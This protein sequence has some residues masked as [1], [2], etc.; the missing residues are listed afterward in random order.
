MRGNVSRALLVIVLLAAAGSWRLAT[1]AQG[2]SEAERQLQKAILV[3]TV[4]GNLQ[5]AIDQYK[6]IVAEN[7]GNRVIAAR[8]LLRL[9]GCYE[10][11]GQTEAEKTYRQLITDYAD[12]A[13]EVALARQKLAALT[14]PPGSARGSAMTVRRVWAGP[15]WPSGMSGDGRYVS[16][17][18]WRTGDLALHD[19]VTSENR[20]ITSNDGSGSSNEYTDS[21]I[22]SPDGKQIAYNWYGKD[23]FYDLRVID[24]D[25][26]KPRVV[27]SDR[28]R[29]RYIQPIAWSPDGVQVL[30][31]VRWTDDTREMMLVR[32]AD[33]SPTILGRQEMSGAVFSPDGRCLAYT[34]KGH[35]ALLDL[36]TRRESELTP[37]VPGQSLLGWSPDGKHLL[38][39]RSGSLWL[40]AVAGGKAEG[41][42]Q[43]VVGN[44]GGSPLGFSR[45]GAFYYS[46]RRSVGDVRVAE[47]DPGNWKMVAAPQPVSSDW[48]TGGVT[49][50]PDWSP[51]GRSLA[52]IRFKPDGRVVVVRDLGTGQERELKVPDAR[53]VLRWMPDGKAVVVSGL[54]AG[55]QGALMRVDVQTGQVSSL[56]PLPASARAF[57]RLDFS[58]DGKAIFFIKERFPGGEGARLVIRDL[59]SGQETEVP[60]KSGLFEK[61]SPGWVSVSPD[62]K[63][64]V[65]GVQDKGKALVLFVMPAAGGEARQFVRIGVDEANYRVAPIW[66]ADGRHVI[67]VKGLRGNP[68][69]HVQVWRAAVEGGSPEPLG[70]TIDELWWLRLHPDGRRVVTGTWTT[71]FE[72]WVMENFLPAAKGG[73]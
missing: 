10:K 60:E 45:S 62:G 44:F 67:F 56:M 47:L 70:L 35:I 21:S 40:I 49:T 15:D 57:P 39:Q 23:N 58:P 18:E 30:A 36:Q 9:A 24:I 17:T 41:E 12:Q 14:P 72:L 33:G 61:Q 52:F 4:D 50:A 38:A 8:A 42:P 71:S 69:R 32:P 1:S 37:E 6:K 22:V 26:T 11:P 53:F 20:L 68:T 31:S 65:V 3:E 34:D 25:G 2:V 13:A 48:A 43:F 73:R 5:A 28:Q 63:R 55:K 59:G 27:F 19:L 29:L 46:T 51:D 66:T 7:G 54:D 16:F 64:L